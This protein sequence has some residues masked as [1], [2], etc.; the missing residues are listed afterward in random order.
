MGIPL[1]EIKH[2]T[3]SNLYLYSDAY[4]LK[5]RKNDEDMYIMACYTYNALETALHN[6]GLIF[7]TKHRGKRIEFIDKPFMYKGEEKKELEDMTEEELDREIMKAIE[8]EQQIM[9][10]TTLKPTKIIISR[11]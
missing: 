6:F 7:D 5:K 4:E 2:S 8:V 10:R 11:R 1:K 3:L 9:N